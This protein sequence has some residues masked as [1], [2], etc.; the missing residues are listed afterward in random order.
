MAALAGFVG[1]AWR[2]PFGGIGFNHS[3]PLG[4]QS[5]LAW[6]SWWLLPPGRRHS[7]PGRLQNLFHPP[8]HF[9][10]PSLFLWR[11]GLADIAVDGFTGANTAGAGEIWQ[12]GC[13]PCPYEYGRSIHGD[14]RG[15]AG[16]TSA[17]LI[18]IC[19]ATLPCAG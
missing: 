12:R 15:S 9:L 5:L 13:Q 10:S 3:I 7:A 6:H 19:G 16:E 18:L 8:G 17:L 11:N 14:D 2:K 1:I 4:G